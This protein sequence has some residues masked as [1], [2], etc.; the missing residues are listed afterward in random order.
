MEHV[1]G[2]KV[3]DEYIFSDALV[4]MG[5]PHQLEEEGQLLMDGA[6]KTVKPI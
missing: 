3:N 1:I 2:K 5:G 6:I 4:K